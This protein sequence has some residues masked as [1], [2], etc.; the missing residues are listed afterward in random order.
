MPLVTI[1]FPHEVSLGGAILNTIV[2]TICLTVRL[3]QHLYYKIQLTKLLLL[4]L[5][6]IVF[7]TLNTLALL[8]FEAKRYAYSELL[9]CTWNLKASALLYATHRV[10]LY[11]FVVWR[12][13][14]LHPNCHK[15]SIRLSKW[16][17][18]IYG[19]FLVFG[20]F[21]Y[22]SGTQNKV[23]ECNLQENE[24]ILIVAFCMDITLCFFASWIFLRP[25]WSILKEYE[26]SNIRRIAKKEAVYVG[27]SLLSTLLAFIGIGFMEGVPSLVIG[28]DS[29]ITTIC[30]LMLLSPV[31]ENGS[32]RST[33]TNRMK[34]PLI[35]G[36][37]AH[38]N[39]RKQST[40]FDKLVDSLLATPT[41]P[42]DKIVV[43]VTKVAYLPSES[44]TLSDYQN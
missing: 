25:L 44:S 2:C 1:V 38:P 39:K 7:S 34:E 30:L 11:A 33:R 40:D 24:T 36:H 32:E 22:T 15:R 3:Y 27:I 31:V 28:L 42:G 10:F 17:M 12:I 29:S 16:A 14:L 41:S 20:V 19:V 43:S 23:W 4:G 8:V 5:C 18:A 26:D 6:S 35:K 21:V 13:G 37:P 9:W